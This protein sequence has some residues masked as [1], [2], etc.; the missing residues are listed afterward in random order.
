[1][2]PATRPRRGPSKITFTPPHSSGER[3][4][5]AQIVAAD[6]LR[7]ALSARPSDRARAEAAVTGLYRRLGEPAPDFVR[8]PSPAAA[9]QVLFDEP[10]RFRPPRLGGTEA[11]ARPAD[12]PLV[13]RLANLAPPTATS[14]AAG[15]SAP[16]R[17]SRGVA[18]TS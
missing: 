13:S 8:V 11:P 17:A 7:H 12:W 5:P 3:V 2:S 10:H 14:Y 1:M 9:R 4:E 18:G 15:A 16:R 6:W